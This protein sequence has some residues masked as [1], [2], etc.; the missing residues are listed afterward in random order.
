[1]RRPRGRREPMRVRHLPQQEGVDTTVSLL[2]GISH[3]RRRRLMH[4]TQHRNS[5][6]GAVAEG[7]EKKAK[8]TKRKAPC[9][10]VTLG[11]KT[12]TSGSDCHAYYKNLMASAPF[13]TNMNE[14]RVD[15]GV[16]DA[17]GLQ[18]AAI[19]CSRMPNAA[20]H[21]HAHEHA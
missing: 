19:A 7:E 12:F 21:A 15:A 2:H 16:Q 13:D 3:A 9:E 10:P 17:R 18:P 5:T 14:V 11:Y 20:T 8:G 4:R 6:A 1:M